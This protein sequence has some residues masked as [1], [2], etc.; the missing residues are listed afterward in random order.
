MTTREPTFE[1]F[2]RAAGHE[3]SLL[4]FRFDRSEVDDLDTSRVTHAFNI[5]RIRRNGLLRALYGRVLFLFNGF[6]DDPRAIHEIPEIRKFVHKFYSAFPYWFYVWEPSGA[7]LAEFV[8]CLLTNIEIT[9]SA[10][11]PDM[12]LSKINWREAAPLINDLINHGWKL[13]SD[14]LTDDIYE[15]RVRSFAAVLNVPPQLLS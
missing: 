9:R 12:A 14:V 15:K 4:V 13:G 5:E 11:R 6:D 10:E 3:A 7:G 1:D 8:F 2:V